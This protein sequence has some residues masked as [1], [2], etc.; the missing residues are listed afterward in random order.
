MVEEEFRNISAAATSFWDNYRRTA[1]W[2]DDYGRNRIKLPYEWMEGHAC[3]SLQGDNGLKSTSAQL[4]G[5]DETNV[6]SDLIVDDD[7]DEEYARFIME[8]KKHQKERGKK[9]KLLCV[10]V[11]YFGFIFSF[12]AKKKAK[13]AKKE[14]KIVFKDIEEIDLIKFNESIVNHGVLKK[15]YDHLYGIEGE[16]IKSLEL[17][18]VVELNEF[19]TSRKPK[20]WPNIPIK[21]NTMTKS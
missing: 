6:K 15:D 14:A 3:L 20:F 21:I 11:M 19:Y 9:E 16:K 10:M 12:T 17:S 2:M 1:K 7:V 18:M 8:T 5:K 4:N 13:K